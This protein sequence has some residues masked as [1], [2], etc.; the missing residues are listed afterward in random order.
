MTKSSK[1]SSVTDKPDARSKPATG[2]DMLH[3]SMWSLQTN[4]LFAT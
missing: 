1:G 4:K 2:N 3:F